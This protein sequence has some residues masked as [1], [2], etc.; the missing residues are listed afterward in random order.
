M[1]KTVGVLIRWIQRKR[2]DLDLHWFFFFNCIYLGS[3]VQGFFYVM[4][5]AP[6]NLSIISRKKEIVV[7][8]TYLVPT[9]RIR[10][11]LK[12]M[13]ANNK[14]LTKLYNYTVYSLY[15]NLFHAKVQYFS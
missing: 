6:S 5:C 15:L 10:P 12:K 3:A 2:S 14:V 1:W 4:L 8:F 7:C 9:F 11:H 13:H